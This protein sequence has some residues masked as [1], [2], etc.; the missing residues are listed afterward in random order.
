MI[1]CS[2]TD[3][4]IEE[5]FKDVEFFNKLIIKVKLF[6]I[7]S[8]KKREIITLLTKERNLFNIILL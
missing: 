5:V 7:K 3:I 2:I 4:F 6:I 1:I 8:D